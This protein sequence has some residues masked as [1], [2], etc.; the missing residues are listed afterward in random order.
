MPKASSD[1][2][3]INYL[4]RDYVL[5]QIRDQVKNL[6]RKNENVVRVVL[7]GSL[8]REDYGPGSDADLLV[9]LKSD[10]RRMMDRIPEFLQ[11]FSELPIAIDVLPMTEKE[12]EGRLNADDLHVKHIINEGLILQSRD[13]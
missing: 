4:D 11:A 3:K 9:V 5:A 13:M 7:F 8:V 6:F 12:L 2:V 1:F 10:S